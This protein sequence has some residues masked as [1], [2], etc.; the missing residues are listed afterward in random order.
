MIENK[1]ETKK[2]QEEKTWSAYSL[3]MNLGF[4][5]VIPIV[6]FGAGGVVLDKKLDCFPIF[7]LIGFV[8]AM[9]SSLLTV[10][11]KTKDIILT[12]KPKHK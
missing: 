12:G 6:I 11:V 3:A 2:Q 9:V 10:Y 8:L 5:I 1:A 4:M 7:T